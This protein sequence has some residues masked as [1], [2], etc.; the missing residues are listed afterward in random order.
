[1]P[2]ER[3]P[4]VAH[5]SR[6]GDLP[7]QAILIVNTASRSGAEAFEPARDKLSAAGIEM[8]DAKAV[9]DPKKMAAA[10]RSAIKRAPMVIVGGGDGTLSQA[11]DH[12]LGKDCVFALLPLG[13]ANSFA[14]SLEIPLDLDGAVDAI[15]KGEARRIDLA[16]INGDHFLNN[17]AL[18]LAP[19][20]AESVPSGLKRTL[21]R[22]GYLLWAGWSAASFKA[23][24]LS[25]DDGRRTH[26]LWATEARIA[27]G[28]F[29]GGIELIESADLESG[30]IVVQAVQGRSVIHLGWSYLASALKHP[31]RHQAVREFRGETMRIDTRPRLRVSIDGELGPETPFEACVVP[32][33]IRVAAPASPKG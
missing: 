30:Q 7:K 9:K 32:E 29:H 4:S 25:V 2:K 24:R 18:G 13:T 31:A 19:M 27:N 6:V 21:G 11:V 28:R 16:S 10:V 15:A 22:L 3:N 8:I 26:R 23:F 5:C 14:R 1:V 33:A 17:A 12:F 20:V